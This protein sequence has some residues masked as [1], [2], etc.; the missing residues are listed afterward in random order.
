MLEVN[1]PAAATSRHINHT[2]PEILFLVSAIAQYMG[3][4]IAVRLFDDIAP[5]TVAWIRVLSA[6]GVL[7]LF[8][9]RRRHKKWTRHDF[10]WASIFGTAT[11][12]MNLFFYLALE[13]LPL[14]K[15][16]TIEFVGPIA[17]AAWTTRTLRNS[18]A[19]VLATAGVL[20]LGGIE[21]GNEPLGLV[22]ILLASAMWA[23]YIVLGSR[24][25]RGDHGIAGLA[26]GL[27]VGAMVITPFASSDIAL[28]VTTPTLL[29]ACI[30]VGVLSNAV[31]YGIDQVTLRRI[32]VRRFSLLLA[33][34]PVTATVFGFAFLDQTPTPIDLAGM[35]LVLLAVVLQERD[36]IERHHLSPQTA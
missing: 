19:L 11:A 36:V 2:P 20:V 26:I 17:V 13:H 10:M 28:A 8:A 6:G 31:G 1:E 33:L 5:A 24:V 35:A 4:V 9:L 15:G 23:A 22:F 12:L 16:V 29:F 21:L 27:V 34:L 18:I 32:P 14:G 30:A 25:A 3:A 7:S